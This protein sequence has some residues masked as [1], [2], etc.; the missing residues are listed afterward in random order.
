M[1]LVILI[2]LSW[3]PF[4]L[5]GQDPVTIHLTEKDGLPDI[6]FYDLHEDK[7][8]YIWLA[9]DKGLYRYDGRDFL[10]FTNEE[11][12]GLSVFELK[13]DPSGR[14]WCNNISGQ[15][16]YI[17]GKKL[18]TFIDLRE[19][20]GGSLA[21]YEVLN[22]SLYI[23]GSKEIFKVD[24]A[25]KKVKSLFKSEPMSFIQRKNDVLQF[26][27]KEYIYEIKNDKITR[28]LDYS[29]IYDSED[30]KNRYAGYPKLLVTDNE[31]YLLQPK[32]IGLDIFKNNGDLQV[33]NFRFNRI[34]NL[35]IVRI[36]NI[37][38]NIWITTN[39]GVYVYDKTLK[40]IGSYLEEHFT[41]KVI[42]DK[43]NNFW[44]STL[45]KGIYVLPNLHV[46]SFTKTE[47][48]NFT[49]IDKVSKDQLFFGT[50][51]G[52]IG[53]YN[54]VSGKFKTFATGSNSKI[55]A[56]AHN[57][58]S[59]EVYISQNNNSSIFNLNTLDITK[60]RAFTSAKDII[61]R[62]K[63]SILFT[64]YYGAALLD[65]ANKYQ[66]I[67]DNTFLSKKRAYTCHKGSFGNKFYVSYVDDFVVYDEN[68]SFKAIK[69]GDASI[70]ATSIT[71]TTD[72][73]VWVSTFKN[74]IYE[75]NDNKVV[76]NLEIKD[77]LSSNSITRIQGD[78]EYLWIISDSAIQYLNTKNGTLM[79]LGRQDG[80]PT[81][82]ITGI[83]IFNNT[84]L[85]S[86]N[87]GFF[88]IN[89]DK[90]FKIHEKP[91]TV[92]SEVRVMGKK[93]P[94]NSTY[95]IPYQDN[96]I[97]ITLNSNTFQ[98][99][100][101]VNYEYRLKESNNQWVYLDDGSNKLRFNSLSSGKYILE[102]RSRIKLSNLS[103][104]S[105]FIT[106]QVVT[107]F[108]KKWW[109]ILTLL[110]LA[111]TATIL[112]VKM[113]QRRV[114]RFNSL[115]LNEA[116]VNKR[117]T[118]LKLQ[119]LRS[120]MNPHFIF[121]AL[122]S[123][124]EFIILNR[125]EEA[126]DFLGK[127]SDLIRGYLSN[128]V[129]EMVSIRDEVEGLENYLALEKMR[130]EESFEYSLNFEDGLIYQNYEIPTMLI[131]PYIENSIKHGLL[132]RKG[133]KVL[134]VKAEKI[135]RADSELMKVDIEDNGIG[136]KRASALSRKH[137]PNH[138]SF[139]TKATEERLEL[140]NTQKAS[141]VGVTY[142]DLYSLEGNP[143][144]TRV[145]IIVPLE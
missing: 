92:I 111:I 98:S 126:S 89:K 2:I 46:K 8:G 120:Q 75:I 12:R 14:L 132:H 112:I 94:L 48:L 144:G 100:D 133:A 15:F 5:L 116:L 84:V 69:Y 32:E 121:N 83:E 113:Q 35:T 51:N 145:T 33:E 135:I 24:I 62:D 34:Q 45:Q 44:I 63:N 76:R 29:T 18:V 49:A 25:T 142:L 125:K 74:G 73:T 97:Q 4:S 22:N 47:K 17:D 56:I 67:T 123:I 40:F 30:F 41:T 38:N 139:G 101:N 143:L 104:D 103:S 36:Q 39:K 43:D 50:A 110:I 131:Q 26:S 128:S 27:D 37:E 53:I 96:T 54:I 77:G 107:P 114:M 88:S 78:G 138:K 7:E 122:N 99:D 65:N 91:K 9:A 52:D 85:F 136:R 140:L 61:V 115:A 72:G 106:L 141:E 86:T 108:W 3:L 129:E 70:F 20:L 87:D 127:F 105:K 68:L 6:E 95:E 102:I 58:I 118:S 57:K 117:I 130:F 19:R 80:I 1:R 66:E 23:I 59:Q 124:Q 42:Q 13:E 82:N 71:E 90:A 119:N 16:F 31:E 28:K 81:Y 93:V 109:F 134:S 64:S 11:K 79:S 10:N 55:I 137:N 21:T 60:S